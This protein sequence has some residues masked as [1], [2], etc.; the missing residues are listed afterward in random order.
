[1]SFKGDIEK[2]KQ[3]FEYVKQERISVEEMRVKNNEVNQGKKP[4]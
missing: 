3:V 2:I 1:M 4:T